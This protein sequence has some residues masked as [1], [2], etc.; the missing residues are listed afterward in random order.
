MFLLFFIS[1]FSVAQDTKWTFSDAKCTIIYSL[2][3]S[4]NASFN[5]QA[6]RLSHQLKRQNA[7]LINLN[8]W[9]PTPQH[10]TISGRDKNLIRQQLDL[11][12]HANQVLIFDRK[13]NLLNRR[14]G[15]VTLV[16]A[17]MDCR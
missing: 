16:D 15:T 4:A 17:L 10:K 7:Q 9:Q 14:T 11:P 2:K 1:H 5:A 3:H 12:I 8:A 13:A 6:N